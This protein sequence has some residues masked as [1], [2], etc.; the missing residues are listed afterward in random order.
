MESCSAFSGCDSAQSCTVSFK[1]AAQP[2]ESVSEEST[3]KDEPP[4]ACGSE[5]A[6]GIATPEGAAS[7]EPPASCVTEK[8]L[9]D[10]SSV[11]QID[12]DIKAGGGSLQPM[13]AE[14]EEVNSQR[15][16]SEGKE[17][18]RKETGQTE[19]RE[20]V[21]SEE[22]QVKTCPDKMWLEQ[23]SLSLNVHIGF[24]VEQTTKGEAMV[25]V[26][27]SS[28]THAPSS[29]ER[30]K[31]ESS[32]DRPEQSDNLCETLDLA[33]ALPQPSAERNMRRRSVPASVSP[34]VGSSLARLTF[35][36]PTS[37]TLDE[38]VP[39]EELGDSR[40][41]PSPADVPSPGGSPHQGFPALEV[42]ATEGVPQTMQQQGQKGSF[43]EK[44]TIRDKKDAPVKPSLILE[45]AVTTGMKPDRL[46]IPTTPSKDRLTEFRLE[47]GLPGDIK[48]QAIPEVDVEKDPSRE[49]SPIPPDTSFTFASTEPG[50][51]TPVT[52][53]TLD[54]HRPTGDE[55]KK[56]VEAGNGSQINE[57]QAEE[58]QIRSVC[59]TR[60]KE[61]EETSEVPS[62]SEVNPEQGSRKPQTASPVIIIPQAQVEEEAEDDNSIGIAEEPREMTQDPETA[63]DEGVEL[64]EAC[65]DD[66]EPAADRAHAST[67][68]DRDP[69]QWTEDGRRE[70]V[71][72]SCSEDGV[73]LK[74]LEEGKVRMGQWDDEKGVGIGQEVGDESTVDVVIHDTDSK[75]DQTIT[76]RAPCVFICLLLSVNV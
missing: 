44:K 69:Q 40:P 59:G 9:L 6:S 58:S 23:R 13:P 28:E 57:D 64:V 17:E 22:L 75:G 52:P 4:V 38:G 29:I 68:F 20:N 19:K 49:A 61:R 71:V 43:P 42:E 14:K 70:E 56:E 3:A 67:S 2:E 7:V 35:G 74:M 5:A 32:P 31:S 25:P 1:L 50:D 60:L 11:K 54:H 72:E 33:G 41:M 51:K 39:P 18:T 65:S 76:L 21:K 53:T 46:R 48:I 15:N 63:K 45:R 10:T 12:V 24:S 37:R 34:P 66:G 27:A 30:L 73:N 47:S 26:E 36:N 16:E 62:A 55:V 8:Q